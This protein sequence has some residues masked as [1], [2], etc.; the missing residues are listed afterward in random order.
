[1]P[2]RPQV[3]FVTNNA[4]D[5]W[6]IVH[7][8]AKKAAARFDV[9]L[10]YRR[11]SQ[12]TVA[13]QKRVID[14]LL[15]RGVQA[16]SVSVID[17]KNQ[18]RYLNL[19]AAKAKLIAVDNDADK[20]KRLLYIG[21]DN[22]KAGRTVGRLIKKSLP[23]GGTL[24]IFVGMIEPLNA[25][26]RWHGVLD[27][28]AG[29]PRD[30]PDDG[31]HATGEWYGK[32]R[33]IGVGPDRLP[34]TD[35]ALPKRA[36]E[37]ADDVLVQHAAEKDLCLVGLW[38]YNPPAIYAAVQAQHL[39]GKVHIVG[40]DED[41]QTLLGIE[42]GHIAATVVQNPYKFGYR[43]VE[44]MSKLVRG[45]TLERALKE[46]KEPTADLANKR[47]Y[48]PERVVT[49]DNVVAFRRQLNELRGN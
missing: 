16:V 14:S 3:A 37:R 29:L 10:F 23:R 46:T 21:T 30:V 1:L 38:A 43:S 22:Y 48:I 39:E 27:E 13:A 49:R 33:L 44:I 34:F 8:G 32:Y 45:K 28:L 36:K 5:F 26:Q 17:P 41:E 6:S 40:F 4:A 7:A 12:G 9:D 2:D 19:V 47:L 42:R 25:R 35:G 24:A 20:T 11:P 31:P 15:V 18:R